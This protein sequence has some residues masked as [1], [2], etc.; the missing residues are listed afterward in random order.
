[1][2]FP[3]SF[4]LFSLFFFFLSF[5][6]SKMFESFYKP[7][8]CF[9]SIIVDQSMQK[10]KTVRNISPISENLLKNDHFI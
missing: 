6:F 8:S 9:S 5:F 4:P 7:Q 1:M 3:E 2:G 10:D